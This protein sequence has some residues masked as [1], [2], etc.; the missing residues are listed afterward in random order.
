MWK[1][2]KP[3]HTKNR[4]N[5]IEHLILKDWCRLKWSEKLWRINNQRINEKKPLKIW[6]SEKYVEQKKLIKNKKFSNFR[7]KNP[8]GKCA[9]IFQKNWNFFRTINSKSSYLKWKETI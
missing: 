8:N 7:K 6:K 4:Y 1:D 3:V 2:Q 5:E 9:N